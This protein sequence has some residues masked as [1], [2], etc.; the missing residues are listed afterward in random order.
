MSTH[1]LSCSS[2]NCKF[3]LV[4][5]GISVNQI[6]QRLDKRIFINQ[7]IDCLYILFKHIFYSSIV[8]SRG[9]VFNQLIRVV[10]QNLRW[11]GALI[12]NQYMNLIC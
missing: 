10:Q 9:E 11:K 5:I 2:E 12:L 6:L 7:E 4:L 8:T 3:H 1:D